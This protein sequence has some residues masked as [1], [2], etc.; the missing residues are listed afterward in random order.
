LFIMFLLGTSLSV[1]AVGAITV[2]VGVAV[3][4]GIDVLDKKLGKNGR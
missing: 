4:F 3:G 1:V 2:G